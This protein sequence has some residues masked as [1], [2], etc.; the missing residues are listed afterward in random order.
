MDK[1]TT[2][3]QTSL[4]PFYGSFATHGVGTCVTHELNFAFP[5]GLQLS[6]G[7]DMHCTLHAGRQTAHGQRSTRPPKK[8]HEEVGDLEDASVTVYIHRSESFRQQL[9]GHETTYCESVTEKA[10]GPGPRQPR[11]RIRKL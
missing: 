7:I 4:D 8:S 9:S 11:R 1:D 2:E 10:T 5:P 3:G 6:R